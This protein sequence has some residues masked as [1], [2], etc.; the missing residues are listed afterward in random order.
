MY[1][2]IHI[3]LTVTVIYTETYVNKMSKSCKEKAIF[4]KNN[5]I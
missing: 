5:F 2:V 3:T 1:I 4:V